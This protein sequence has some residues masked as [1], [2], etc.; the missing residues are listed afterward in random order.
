[1]R[2]DQLIHTGKPVEKMTG[3]LVLPGNDVLDNFEAGLSSFMYISKNN[4]QNLCNK[5]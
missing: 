2:D 3:L 4:Q 5:N 1:M